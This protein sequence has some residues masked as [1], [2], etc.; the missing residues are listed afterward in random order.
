MKVSMGRAFWADR[1]ADVKTLRQEC[2]Y[3]MHGVERLEAK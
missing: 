1:T 3:H 2:V